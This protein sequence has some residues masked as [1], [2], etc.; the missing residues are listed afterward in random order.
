MTLSILM[1]NDEGY[2]QALSFSEHRLKFY[3]RL[4]PSVIS[5]AGVFAPDRKRVE[6]FIEEKFRQSYGAEIVRHYP[7]LMSVRDGQD[8]ILGALGFRYAKEEP[9]FLEQYLT[10]NIEET[11]FRLT[12]EHKD[13]GEFVE[14]GNL[15]SLGDGASIFLFTA[16]HA[17]LLQHG[18][19]T[20][21]VTATDFLHRYFLKLGLKPHVL[22]PANQAL[23]PDGGA[24]WGSYYQAN[25]RIITGDMRDTYD[26]LKRHL[27][28]SFSGDTAGLRARLHPKIITE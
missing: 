2:A 22:G 16:M 3:T 27:K 21:A 5:I 26:R 9:L 19:T 7:I 15:A 6:R 24:S 20:I 12:G 10:G 13:R 1:T 14:S 18:F 8:N 4:S 25:P 11:H 17:Y 23:L 28:L